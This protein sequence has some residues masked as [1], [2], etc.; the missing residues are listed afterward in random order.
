MC[1]LDKV[2]KVYSHA[3]SL[4][5]CHEWLNRNLPGVPRA[6]VA[7]NSLAAQMAAAEEGAAGYRCSGGAAAG[8]LQPAAAGEEYRGRAEPTTLFL[9]SASRRWPRQDKTSLIMSA[10][11]RTGSPHDLLEPFAAAGYR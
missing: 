8:T 6:S 4:A 9:V 11:N 10:P 1:R 3:Q 2:T 5:Q 7:S